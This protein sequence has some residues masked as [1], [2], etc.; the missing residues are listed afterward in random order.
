MMIYFIVIF[1]FF[2]YLFIIMYNNWSSLFIRKRPKIKRLYYRI[3]IYSIIIFIIFFLI[4]IRCLVM[5][6]G[7]GEIIYLKNIRDGDVIIFSHI[8]SIYDAPVDEI[9]VVNGENLILKDIKTQSYGVKEYYQITEKISPRSFKGIILR[10]SK[11]RDFSVTVNGDSV[12]KLKEVSDKSINIAL[13]YM[14][15]SKYLWIKIKI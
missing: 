9:L 10:N 8:N 12:N 6:G 11:D 14:T 15:V 3:F 5:K 13:Q 4:P 1:D 2:V 7:D